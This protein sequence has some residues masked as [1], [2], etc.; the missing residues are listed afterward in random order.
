[1]KFNVQRSILIDAPKDTVKPLVQNFKNWNSWSPWTVAEPDCPIEIKG[2]P[3]S[4]G[5]SMSWEGQIIGSGQNVLASYTDQ[6]LTYDLSFFKPFKSQAKTAFLF[7]EKNGSTEVTWTMDSQMPFFMFF[8]IPTMKTMIEMDYDRGLRMLKAVAEEGNVNATTTNKG[9]VAIE[10]FSYVGLKRT[11]SIDDIGTEMQK[12]YDTLT[13][14][15]VHK[16]DIEPEQWV[17]LYPKMNM[18]KREMTYIAA[19]SDEKLTEESLPEQYVRGT[20]KS[21]NALEIRHD[22]PYDFIGNAWGM[23][24]MYV[25]SKKIK[26]SG[27]PFEKYW[28]HPKEVAPEELQTSIYFPLKG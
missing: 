27:V 1:M 10:E 13:E 5:H 24:T 8:M 21:G 6:N 17:S 23:G 25:R 12:D 26:Q 19:I 18:K 2:D 15:L 9:V 4:P 7:Q 16:Y 11:V 28:N 20:V 3:Q 22:G 14:D